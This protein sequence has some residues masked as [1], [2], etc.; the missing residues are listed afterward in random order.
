MAGRM[1][2]CVSPSLNA[3]T[4]VMRIFAISCSLFGVLPTM[5]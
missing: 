3:R 5:P 2:D 4:A 1:T